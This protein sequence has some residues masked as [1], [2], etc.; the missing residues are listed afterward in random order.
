MRLRPFQIRV[1]D[2]VLDDLGDRLARTRFLE[3]GTEP[4][5]AAGVDPN[6]LRDLVDYWARE[7]DWRAREVVLNSAPQYVADIGGQDLHFI[8]VRSTRAAGSTPAPPLILVHGWPSCFVEMLPLAERLSEPERFGSGTYLGYDVVIPSLPGFLYSSRVSGPATRK[9]MA[10][11]LHVLMSEVLGYRRYAAFGA[12]IGSGVVEWLSVLNP[13]VVVGI[14]SIHP[15]LSSDEATGPLTTA[16]GEWLNAVATYDESDQGYSEIMR[17]RPYTVGAALLDSPAGLAAWLVD[18]F[19]AWS[20]CHGQVESRF[21]RDTLLTIVTLYWVTGCIAESFRPYLDYEHNEPTP[22]IT[23]PV[24]VT[25]SA[26]P[27]MTGFPKTLAER[28]C[29]DL[30]YWS[31]PGRGG[32]FMPLEEPDLLSQELRAFLAALAS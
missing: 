11:T 28:A 12:D 13:D 6:Y 24:G 8:H 7:F 30:R 14:H 18:K 32:H 22:K 29:A 20:D 21:D 23:V 3:R 25:L 2:Q 4:G 31:E 15:P 5:W 16:E 1:P 17:T 10:Q 26:E 27:L 19:R 9:A